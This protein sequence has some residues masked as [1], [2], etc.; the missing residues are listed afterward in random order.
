MA[1]EAAKSRRTGAASCSPPRKTEETYGRTE[2]DEL[3]EGLRCHMGQATAEVV[4]NAT[5]DMEGRF[6][7]AVGDMFKK[8]EGK[9]NE[10]FGTNEAAT[11]SLE[12]RVAAMEEKEKKGKQHIEQLTVAVQSAAAEETAPPEDTGPFRKPDAALVRFRADE[13]ITRKS[14]EEAMASILEGMRL[15]KTD[16]NITGPE[17]GQG[18]TL[19]FKGTGGL[20]SRRVNKFMAL[21]KQEWIADKKDMRAKL[22]GGGDTRVYADYDK[23]AGTV[24]QE[25]AARRLKKIIAKECPHLDVYLRKKECQITYK[26]RGGTHH[27]VPLARTVVEETAGAVHAKAEWN[28]ALVEELGLDRENLDATLQREMAGN[29]VEV[30]WG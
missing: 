1:F 18:F 14:M 12:Q 28:T 17:L 23:N 19:R 22:A 29:M 5:K 30:Q 20:A 11:R 3:M 27:W 7:G 26:E 6:L 13:A 21:Q 8:H 10:R 24:R 16:F 4:K 9:I 15:A 25:T 2:V